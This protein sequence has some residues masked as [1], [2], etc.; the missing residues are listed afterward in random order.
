MPVHLATISAMSAS[1]HLLPQQGFALGLNFQ[2]LGFLR[3]PLALYAS[4]LPY[5]SWAALLRS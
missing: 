2:Q 4:S 1:V 5:L 3:F